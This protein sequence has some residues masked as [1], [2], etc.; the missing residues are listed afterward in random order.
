MV[1]G[2]DATVPE[3]IQY[4]LHVR[5]VLQN[6]EGFILVDGSVRLSNTDDDSIVPLRNAKLETR[7]GLNVGMTF[8]LLPGALHTLLSQTS[9]KS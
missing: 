4:L 2:S 6:P 1:P 9:S 7:R 3:L 5:S 8:G